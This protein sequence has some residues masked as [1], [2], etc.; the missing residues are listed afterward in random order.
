[1]QCCLIK[2][3]LTAKEHGAENR[4]TDKRDQ[5]L[6]LAILSRTQTFSG[7]SHEIIWQTLRL[8]SQPTPASI[9]QYVFHVLTRHR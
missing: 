4:C 9:S 6:V 3:G 7:S 5:A 1:M 2:V 8:D